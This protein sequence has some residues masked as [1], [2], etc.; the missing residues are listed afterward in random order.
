[1]NTDLK[2][3]YAIHLLPL[4]TGAVSASHWVESYRIDFGRR[5]KA[6]I[7]FSDKLTSLLIPHRISNDETSIEILKDVAFNLFVLPYLEFYKPVNLPEYITLD[8]L[9]N[10]DDDEL[11]AKGLRLDT[12]EFKII[13]MSNINEKQIRYL[14]F[15]FLFENEQKLR[16]FIDYNITTGNIINVAGYINKEDISLLR[17]FKIA[18]FLND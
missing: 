13:S 7:E 5:R 9:S 17:K 14:E 11:I 6:L 10:D 4:I 1:M 15:S 3:A 8:V 12:S 18:D 2:E 16:I